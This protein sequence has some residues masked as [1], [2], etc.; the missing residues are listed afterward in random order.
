MDLSDLSPNTRELY[1]EGDFVRAVIHPEDA[2]SNQIH[3]V[4]KSRIQELDDQFDKASNIEHHYTKGEIREEIIIDFF[5]EIVPPKHSVEGGFICDITGQN[6]PQLDFIIANTSEIPPVVL[7]SY[8]SLVPPESA[9]ATLEVKSN[10]RHKD[11]KTARKTSR[12]YK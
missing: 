5:E 2:V 10:L 8:T 9:I 3:E 11:K 1:V 12:E 7:G 4:I 6:T